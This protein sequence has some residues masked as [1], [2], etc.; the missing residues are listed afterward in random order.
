LVSIYNYRGFGGRLKIIGLAGRKGSG[1]DTV[2]NILAQN[3]GFTKIAFADPLKELLVKVFRV[4]SQYL[5][6][7]KLK[8]GPLPERIEIDYYH[9]DKIRDIVENQWG[10][11][12]DRDQ[13]E[14]IETFFGREI[15]TARELMQTIG[16]DLLRRY[17]RDDIFIVLL[18]ARMREIASNV[19]I[20]DVRLKNEREAIKKAGGS[21]ILIK[22]D[23]RTNDTHISENDLGLDKEYDVTIKNDDITLNQLRSEVLMWYSVA[24]KYKK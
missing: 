9:L 3:E 6:D 22:R 19:V 14:G 7:E 24:M 12:I 17:V 1:K 5:H 15:R 11:P 8:E 13:R 18:S 16:T 4:D 21:M 23:T 20:S 2:A 10:F